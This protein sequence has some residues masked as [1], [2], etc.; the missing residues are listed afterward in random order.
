MLNSMF[1][2]SQR[3]AVRSPCLN[4]GICVT[5]FFFT[6]SILSC[7]FLLFYFS[8]IV[9]ATIYL[10]AAAFLSS[11]YTYWLTGSRQVPNLIP[12]RAFFL[13]VEA[14]A[15][16]DASAIAALPSFQYE[17]YCKDS[18]NGIDGNGWAQCAICIGTVQI[19]EMVRN[20][21]A[22]KHLFHAECIDMWLSSH[23]TCPMCRT[24]VMSA[25]EAQPPV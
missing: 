24:I 11:L 18:S 9:W 10:C 25:N 19:G 12:V 15:G 13:D 4:G 14:E 7:F 2:F 16:L 3:R 23:S 1:Q 21:P 17:R 8:G 20:L 6:I 22:C 5:I